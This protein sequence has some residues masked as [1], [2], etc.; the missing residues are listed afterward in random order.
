MPAITVIIP[1]TTVPTTTPS[2]IIVSLAM[3][4]LGTGANGEINRSQLRLTPPL[5]QVQRLQCSGRSI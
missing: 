1:T 4:G 3:H 5:P 2:V